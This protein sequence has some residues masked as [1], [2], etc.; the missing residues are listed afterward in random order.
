MNWTAAIGAAIERFR[1]RQVQPAP[2]VSDRPA[3]WDLV[4]ADLSGS[5]GVNLLFGDVEDGDVPVPPSLVHAVQATALGMSGARDEFGL[6]KYGTRLQPGNGRDAFADYMQERMDG[7]VYLRIAIEDAAG[8]IGQ[9]EALQSLYESEISV[10]AVAIGIWLG[11]VAEGL[12]VSA[13][14]PAC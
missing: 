4:R 9:R 3:A 10:S 8:D 13:G 7:L 5:A 14:E 12:A 6:R 11:M 2:V 1:A